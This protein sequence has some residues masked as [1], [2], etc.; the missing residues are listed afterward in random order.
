MLT[1]EEDAR[2]A[3]MSGVLACDE[4][5]LVLR[6]NLPAHLARAMRIRLAAGALLVFPALA[7]LICRLL[8]PR[9]PWLPAAGFGLV[10]ALPI[11]YWLLTELRLVALQ[12]GDGVHLE[13]F[14]LVSHRKSS[15]VTV[16]REELTGFDVVARVEDERPFHGID[17]HFV[18]RL[19]RAS[20]EPVEAWITHSDEAAQLAG[21]KALALMGR[22][23]APGA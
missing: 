5:R 10:I 17:A 21:R 2:L 14:N 3:A 23:E 6:V 4:R 18:M 13:R 8:V 15:R 20:G 19:L 12:G 11:A 1:T 9:I 22:D 16:R 7:A